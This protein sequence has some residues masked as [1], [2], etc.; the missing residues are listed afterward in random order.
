MNRLN[1]VWS[2]FFSHNKFVMLL[3]SL[4]IYLHYMQIFIF[5]SW[6][7]SNTEALKRILDLEIQL[8]KRNDR[9]A[10]LEQKCAQQ[11]SKISQLELEVSKLRKFDSSANQNVLTVRLILFILFKIKM[12]IFGQ[13]YFG[14]FGL[15]LGNSV[16]FGFCGAL[17]MCMISYN[18]ILIT[19]FTIIVG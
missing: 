9:I 15:I 16:R 13:V 4:F 1:K 6:K 8:Y 7:Q 2:R 10:L 11:N 17:C 18:F 3:K 19:H 12:L 5:S 14:I